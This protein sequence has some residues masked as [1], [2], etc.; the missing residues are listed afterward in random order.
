MFHTI[1]R[2]TQWAGEYKKRLYLGY[3]CSFCSAWCVAAPVMLGAWLLEKIL[4]DSKGE[5]VLNEKYVF[6]SIAG[7]VIAILLRFIFTYWKNIL[8]ESIGCEIAAKQR[9]QIGDVLKRVS[10]G[11]FA[12]K[13]TGDILTAVTTELSTLELQAMKMVDV[14]INGYLQVAATVC[15][16]AFI[17]LPAAIVSILGILISALGLRGISRQSAFTAP[18][19]HKAREDM[20]AASIEYIRG[21]AVVKSFGQE[22]ASTKYFK[23][24]IKDSKDICI[25]NEYGF[26]PWNCFHLFSLKTASVILVVIAAW[27]A[28]QGELGIPMFFMLCF[29]SFSIFQSV[30]SINDGAH[31][32][33]VID[34]VLD[35]LEEMEEAPFLDKDG[36]DIKLNNYEIL[37]DKVSFGYGEREILHNI[38]FH[39][40]E[41]TT[42]AIVGPSGSGKSTICNLIAKFY[43][44]NGGSITIG[45]F[46][47]REFT[48][49][50]L[51]KYVSMVFQNVYLFHDTVANNIKFGKQDAT[52]E[53][54]IEAAKKARCHDFILSLPEGYDT[55]LGEGGSSLSGG[56]KQRVSIARAILKDA[57]IIILDEATAS[58]DPE[59][60]AQIQNA[61]SE[62]T[63]NKTIIIIAHRLATIEQA[64]QI[65]VLDEGRIVQQGSHTE[66]INQQGIYKKFTS[67]RE[68][69]EGWRIG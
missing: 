53:E 60:E 1:K 29:F 26:V 12:E 34:K 15:F 61:I 33:S 41:K 32:L 58:I 43:D 19:G 66:L 67:I 22:G 55:V 44:V 27:E 16:I 50:S 8:Q 38:T 65:L 39:I 69:A 9:I 21:L 47:I 13:K 36:R 63:K 62:L 57:P 20:S 25:K 52:K 64:D 5:I 23:N 59:N 51:L 45:G 7:M 18:I 35:K 24:A 30:E 31:I 28:F 3:I 4:A 40:P 6:Y 2:I 48:C 10:L 54:I 37:F 42:T 56:E 46:D 17:S 11:Y 14:V 49:D 68:R